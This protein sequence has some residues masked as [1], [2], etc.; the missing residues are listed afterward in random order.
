VAQ[1]LCGGA[2][3][4]KLGASDSYLSPAFSSHGDILAGRATLGDKSPLRSLC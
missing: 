4:S 1:K 2:W 3:Q